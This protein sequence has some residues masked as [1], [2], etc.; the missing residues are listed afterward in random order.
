MEE[1]VAASA[2]GYYNKENKMIEV[3]LGKSGYYTLNGEWKSSTGGYF[4]TP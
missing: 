2:S 4:E 3:K 1:L